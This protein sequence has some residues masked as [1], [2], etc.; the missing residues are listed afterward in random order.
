MISFFRIASIALVIALFTVGSLPATGHAFP[1][2]LHWGVH[3]FTYALISFCMGMGW[4]KLPAAFTA[5]IVAA[6]GIVHEVTEIVTHS[7]NFEF[8]DAVINTLG[9]LIG[10][11][12]LILVRKWV[13]DTKSSSMESRQ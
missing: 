10:M 4:Q 8:Y 6:I 7:H 5:V 13:L 3:L 1:G 12:I 11:A 9:A 2:N